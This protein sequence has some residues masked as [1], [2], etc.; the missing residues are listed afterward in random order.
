MLQGVKK[1]FKMSPNEFMTLVRFHNGILGSLPG[2]PDHG[3]PEVLTDYELRMILFNAM[4]PQYQRDFKKAGFK[5]AEDTTAN[6][7][8]YFEDLY[9]DDPIVSQQVQGPQ[10]RYSGNSDGR[11]NTLGG[12]VATLGPRRE[13]S[14]GRGYRPSRPAFRGYDNGRRG[15]FGR[16]DPGRGSYYGR[17][18]YLDSMAGTMKEAAQIIIRLEMEDTII[19]SVGIM[20]VLVEVVS[21]VMEIVTITITGAMET[22]MVGMRLTIMMRGRQGATRRSQ[23]RSR[24]IKK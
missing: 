10:G 18:R 16:R 3:P 1:P 22:I 12:R 23:W 5:L 2:H 21:D 6:V 13:T 7:E 9:C 24:S 11:R 14:R 15:G 17:P 4:P 19:K 20:V 8:G